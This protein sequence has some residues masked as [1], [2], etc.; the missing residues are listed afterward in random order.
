M[1]RKVTCDSLCDEYNA[2]TKKARSALIDALNERGVENINV[3]SYMD[4][5]MINWFT[6]PQ[7]DKNGYGVNVRIDSIYKNG[8]GEW[9][10]DVVDEDEDD[11]GTIKFTNDYSL[12]ASELIDILD[13]VEEI[14]A[15]ADEDYNGKVLAVGEDFDDIEN[16]E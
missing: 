7:T 14:F 11:W 2:L 15:V 1:E 9:V 6:F 13:I 10:A 5:D 8:N 3:K 16:E 4:E 12:G